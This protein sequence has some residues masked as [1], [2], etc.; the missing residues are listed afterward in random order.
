MELSMSQRAAV[1]KRL[2]LSYKRASKADKSR[3]LDELV[4]LTGWHR[5]YARAAIR[6]AGSV[7]LVA[8]RKPRAPM[9]ATMVPL[10]RRD[11]DIV[12]S[13]AEAALLVSM[14]AAT[15]DRHLAAQRALLGFKGRSH[16]KPGSLLK[17]QI[18]IRTWA[19]GAR[20]GPGS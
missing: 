19:S 13:D 1:T 11:G 17:S 2:A 12:L 5:D 18:P 15:I 6:S 9:L 14:S 16:T 20:I 8:P 7:K 4:E 3:I 10:L